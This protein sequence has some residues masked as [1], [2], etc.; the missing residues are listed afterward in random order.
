MIRVIQLDNY[1]A[2]KE[3]FAQKGVPFGPFH[4]C[5][6][7]F[8]GDKKIGECFYEYKNDAVIIKDIFPKNDFLLLDGILRSVFFVASNKGVEKA[9]YE[10]SEHKVLFEKLGFLLDEKYKSLK[11]KKIFE[12]CEGCKKD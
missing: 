4:F 11:I 8:D 5:S 2:T 3:A 9:F 10:N 12:T 7:S 1:E 6:A